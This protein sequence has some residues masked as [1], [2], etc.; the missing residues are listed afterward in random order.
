VYPT[1]I[2]GVSDVAEPVERGQLIG[3][4]RF[5]RD[6]GFVVGALVAGVVADRLGAGW[7]IA[8]VAGLT[9]GSGIWVALTQWPRHPGTR[10]RTAASLLAEARRRIDPRLEPAD[11]CEASSRGALLVDLRSQDERRHEGIIPGS[12]H[13]PRSVLEWRVD[14]DSG[15]A[16]PHIG[17][18]DRQIVLF[19]AEGFSS[20]LAAATL[21]DLGYGRATDMVGGFTAWKAARLPVRALAEDPRPDPKLLPGLGSP[22][23]VEPR[24]L[25][26]EAT[27]SRPVDSATD[28]S[29]AGRSSLPF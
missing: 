13:I 10:R 4:Y 14:P 7:A 15:V 3:V 23:P 22:E 11:A 20:S 26:S 19:C 16:N 12:L 5:W 25:L 21:R 29:A 17:G 1:L 24:A 8:L 28:S 27:A 18:L 9:A 6:F 2:A